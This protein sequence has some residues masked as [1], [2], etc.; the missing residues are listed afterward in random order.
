MKGV[1]VWVASFGDLLKWLPPVEEGTIALGK[2]LRQKTLKA[3]VEL[4]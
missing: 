4:A 3:G 2:S 1:T